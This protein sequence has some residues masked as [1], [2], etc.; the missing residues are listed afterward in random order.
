MV[1]SSHIPAS[2][3]QT[4]HDLK[5]SAAR[6][7]ARNLSYS[8]FV[9]LRYYDGVFAEETKRARLEAAQ[10]FLDHSRSPHTFEKCLATPSSGD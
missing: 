6:L 10:V 1:T 9:L 8:A 3:E 7:A 5:E 4:I 2:P